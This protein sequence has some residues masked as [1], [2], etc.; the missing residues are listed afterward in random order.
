MHVLDLS[1]DGEMPDRTSAGY[2]MIRAPTLAGIE[3][4]APVHHH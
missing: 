2:R 4:R 1:P 3:V